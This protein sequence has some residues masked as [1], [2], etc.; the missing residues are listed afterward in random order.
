[1]NYCKEWGIWEG[2]REILQNQMDG[3]SSIIGKSNIRVNPKEPSV[4]NIKYQ[5]DFIHKDTEEIFGQIQ[6]KEVNNILSVWNKGKLET[7]D[8]LLGG[9]KDTLNSEEIIGR[10]GEGMKLAALAFVRKNK[11]FSIITDGQLWSFVQENDPNFI[12]NGQPQ[13][14]LK[15]KGERINIERYN[16]KVTIEINPIA[17][18]EWIPFIDNFLWLTQ[19]NVGR[20]YAKDTNGKI[21]GQLLYNKFFYNK[22]Y[23][24]DIFVQKTDENNGATTCYFGYNT[25]LTL[26]RDRN[27]VKNLDERN[28]S[29]SHILGDIMNRRNSNE[30]IENLESEDR[31]IFLEEY[32][33]QIIFLLEHGFYTCVYINQH[34]TTESRDALWNQKVQEDLT[35]RRGKNIIYSP[36]LGYFQHWMVEKKLPA[37]FFPYFL[38]GHDWL[39]GVLVKSSYYKTYEQIYNEKII[40]SPE[41]N[42]PQNLKNIIDEI[43]QIVQ[44]VKSDFQ[45]NCIKFKSFGDEFQDK[46]IC[47]NNNVIYFSNKLGNVN[48]DRLKKFWML[49]TVCHFFKINSMTLLI[50]S[51]PFFQN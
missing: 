31:L 34:L 3:I 20:I 19:R 24:K 2:I 16:N 47:F 50:N 14:C 49:E 9:L 21:I 6:Y 37:S 4:N 44:T 28:K 15:W 32:P 5:F 30:V 17:L 40:G 29:F 41:V 33:K 43:V 38:I 23:V 39:W 7:G 18:N 12:K 26:D 1:M 8:L 22:I 10:F 45:R 27:A 13:S 46:V 36:Y 42:E 51:S 48:I 25:D 35:N 11:R